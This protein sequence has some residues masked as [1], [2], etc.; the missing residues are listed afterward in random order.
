VSANPA[1]GGTVS[2]GGTFNYG[3]SCTVSAT[4]ATGYTF[5][6]WTE[7]GTQ[8][9]TNPSYTFNVTGN[10]TLVAQFQLQGFAITVSANPADGGMVNGGGSYNYG[11]NCTVGAMA[12][13]GYSFINWTENG[14]EVST[15]PSY[16]FNVTGDRTLVA[17][18]ERQSFEV[19]ASLD[20]ADA[21]YVTGEGT[22][23]YGDEVT[24]TVVCNEDFAFLNWTEDGEVVSEDPIYVFNITRTRNLVAHFMHTEGVGEQN[25]VVAIY[26]NPVSD[27]LTVEAQ[28]AIENVEVYNLV[29]ALVIS[30]KDQTNKVELSVSDLPA[31]TYF[32][33]M[34]TQSGS[35]TRS[36]VKK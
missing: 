2:G 10:R 11:Q 29:G 20:P 36:F 7:N 1:D 15:N 12:N 14:N 17:N 31:G 8:I 30:K 18:F 6:R 32:I 9:S 23:Y 16:T 28:E 35:E 34:T 27:I 13:E 22:Y 3:Q 33:R 19:K 5:L 24:L 25:G 4:P 21:G 26:P